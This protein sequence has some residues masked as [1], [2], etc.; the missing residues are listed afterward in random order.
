MGR[1]GPM[2][3]P[4]SKTQRGNRAIVALPGGLER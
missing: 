1:R 2:P 4:D 3:K